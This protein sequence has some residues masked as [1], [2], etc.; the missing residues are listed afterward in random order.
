MNDY[1][2]EKQPPRAMLLTEC[3]MSG[4]IASNN[5]NVELIG[6]CQLCPHMQR[7]TLPKILKS[8][9]TMGEEVI[10]D[11]AIAERARH[12]IERMLDLSQ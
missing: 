9:Q 8:L 4:N 6:T 3:S 5:P 11:P 1:I 7:I 2:V 12:P 10:I